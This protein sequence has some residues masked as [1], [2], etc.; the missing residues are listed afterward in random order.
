MQKD[1]PHLPAH[2][3]NEEE[4]DEDEED[5]EEEEEEEE[6]VVGTA[7]WVVR[8]ASLAG[9]PINDNSTPPEPLSSSPPAPAATAVIDIFFFL[10]LRKVSSFSSVFFVYME[11]RNQKNKME[12]AAKSSVIERRG[13][14]LWR[15]EMLEQAGVPCFNHNMPRDLLRIM[16]SYWVLLVELGFEAETNTEHKWP[17]AFKWYYL[18]LTHEPCRLAAY[19]VGYC[20]LHGLRAVQVEWRRAW[21]ALRLA[22]TTLGQGKIEEREYWGGAPEE[23]DHHPDEA[24]S[25]GGGSLGWGWWPMAA[26]AEAQAGS[27]AW[28]LMAYCLDGEEMSDNVFQ[29]RKAEAMLK[30]GDD[31]YAREWQYQQEFIHH[32]KKIKPKPTRGWRVV[33][34]GK[35]KKVEDEIRD[36][37]KKVEDEIRKRA[38]RGDA[39]AI[40][41]LSKK[42]SSSPPWAQDM[43]ELKKQEAEGLEWLH[44]A[45]ALGDVVAMR[46]WANYLYYEKIQGGGGDTVASLELATN[47]FPQEAKEKETGPVDNLEQCKMEAVRWWR[48]AASCGDPHAMQE[49]VTR[50]LVLEFNGGKPEEEVNQQ[51]QKSWLKMLHTAAAFGEISIGRLQNCYAEGYLGLMPGTPFPYKLTTRSRK[52]DQYY[53]I[54]SFS[55]SPRPRTRS[56][57]FIDYPFNYCPI[58]H[59][60]ATTHL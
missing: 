8:T 58:A 7:S 54:S 24:K 36:K 30:E 21:E 43:Q 44:K 33:V 38:M 9:L 56:K 28:S 13:P 55:T 45:I 22:A 6:E 31:C 29:R 3:N 57:D 19:K 48:E 51:K 52:K 10:L 2:L 60:F 12:E 4:D 35:A 34:D 59:D 16:A 18:A 27:E 26:E 47:I 23:E 46:V 17:E 32:G 14:T 1:L 42:L 49:Y 20:Y 25:G 11:R 40:Y 39:R 41:H 15:L 53:N 37:A 50:L 5:E